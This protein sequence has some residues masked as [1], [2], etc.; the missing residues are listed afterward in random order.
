VGRKPAGQH[1]AGGF[2]PLGDGSMPVGDALSIRIFECAVVGRPS[3]SMMSFS[4]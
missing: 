3:T 4:A 1:A 2:E